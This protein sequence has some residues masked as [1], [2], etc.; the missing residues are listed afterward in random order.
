MN[1]VFLLDGPAMKLKIREEAETIPTS[2][3]K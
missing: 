2:E 1:L 3:N